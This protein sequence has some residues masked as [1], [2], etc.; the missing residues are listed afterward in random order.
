MIDNI[1]S[2]TPPPPP[3]KKREKSF[4]TIMNFFFKYPQKETF[5]PTHKMKQLFSHSKGNDRT[6][7]Y[8]IN[9]YESLLNDNW[10]VEN[11]YLWKKINK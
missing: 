8:N 2:S 7:C 10:A 5:A 1:L 3:I 4:H 6:H 9:F 11:T